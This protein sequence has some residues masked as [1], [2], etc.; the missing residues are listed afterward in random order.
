V[1]TAH[2]DLD[3]ALDFFEHAVRPAEGAKGNLWWVVSVGN[4]PALDVTT[5]RLE[6]RHRVERMSL[7]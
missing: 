6:T 3:E 2:S 1:T 7:V 4:D 5:R